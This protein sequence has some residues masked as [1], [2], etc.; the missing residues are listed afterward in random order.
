MTIVQDDELKVVSTLAMPGLTIAQNVFYARYTAAAVV[1]EDDVTD[2]M[3]AWVDDMFAGVQTILADVV[4]L[5]EVTVYKKVTVSP[6]EFEQIGNLPGA[7]IGLSTDHALPNGVALVIR[8]G[9]VALRSIA[10]KYIGGINEGVSDGPDWAASALAGGA[11]FLADWIAGPATVSGRTYEAGIVSTK[12]GL[13]KTFL[14]T[15]IVSSIPGYQ[16]RRKPGVGV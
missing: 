4:S 10:R 1:D 7:R 3:L 5:S 14:P 15:G 16:R 12:D 2:D 9:T 11:A 13:F 6:L 8:V